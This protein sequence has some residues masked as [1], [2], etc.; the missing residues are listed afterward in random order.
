MARTGEG[1]ATVRFYQVSETLESA[2][3]KVVH[4]A[5]ERGLRQCVVAA[6]VQHARRL[7]DLLWTLPVAG[8]LPHRLWNASEPER[9][10]LLIALEP[11]DRNAA[12]VLVS[13]HGEPFREAARFDLVIDFV[14]AREPDGLTRG[15]DRFRFYRD[16]G[17]RME[18]WEQGAEG[19][20]KKA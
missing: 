6:G 18:Y 13:A 10:P 12:T 5:H 4:K 15:R 17:H 16:Q 1:A 20:Q 2:L 11:D 14:D 8:F 7:D 19:W 9:Q 3:L